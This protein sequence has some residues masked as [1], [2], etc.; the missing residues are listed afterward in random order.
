M[1]KNPNFLEKNFREFY[2]AICG[3]RW[4]AR[5]AL[6]LLRFFAD[7][8]NDLAY[9]APVESVVQWVATTI[10]R[11]V[12]HDARI[13]LNNVPLKSLRTVG[14]FRF[15]VLRTILFPRCRLSRG[16]LL[17]RAE[18]LSESLASLAEMRR[19][20]VFSGE[21]ASYGLDPI[22]PRRRTAGVVWQRML[23]ALDP[24]QP[25]PPWTAP[26]RADTK[27]LRRV[28]AAS[29]SPKMVRGGAP[30]PSARLA[31]GTMVALF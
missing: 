23:G 1:A 15:R 14:E 18:R 5:R 10:D 19:I 11:L 21:K 17:G 28:H 7:V 26:R 29:W 13:A 3:P 25:A 16:E 2:R 8:G 20:P 12:A 9:E 6:Q 4:S 22:H 27:L 31:D 30:P 24:A